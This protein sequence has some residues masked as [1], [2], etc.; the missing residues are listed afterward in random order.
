MKY[1]KT[2]ISAAFATIAAAQP[3]LQYR[4]T[5]G[6]AQKLGNTL[7]QLETQL[8]ESEYT[9]AEVIGKMKFGFKYYAD[10]EEENEESKMSIENFVELV[11]RYGFMDYTKENLNDYCKNLDGC[12]E[13][14][15]CYMYADE[16]NMPREYKWGVTCLD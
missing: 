7:A 16:F 13:D 3:T 5:E 11:N 8:D 14:T 10:I 4:E 2:I 6:L 1:I 9:F 12:S 15:I